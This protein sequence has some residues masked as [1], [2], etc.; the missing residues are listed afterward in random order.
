M[1]AF[2]SRPRRLRAARASVL[3]PASVVTMNAYQFPE[4]LDI[5]Q[6]GAKLRG[7]SL[8]PVNT[9][10]LLRVGSFQTLCRVVWV[11]DEH[12]GVRF[13][14]PI[15]H[16]VLKEIQLQ[17]AVAIEVPSSLDQ[18][19]ASA[20]AIPVDAASARLLEVAAEYEAITFATKATGTRE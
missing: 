11:A 9:T 3:M 10:G 12:C 4:L 18:P 13:E 17:G 7:S 2:S 1:N 14:E 8:P 19:S 15:P 20:T 5:S 16:K 6:T